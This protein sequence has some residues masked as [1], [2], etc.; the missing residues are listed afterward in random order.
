MAAE[1]IVCDIH[2]TCSMES[3]HMFETVN[4]EFGEEANKW[5]PFRPVP[6]NWSSIARIWSCAVIF[7]QV[8]Q[9]L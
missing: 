9:P 5:I 4:T 7:L 2:R 8:A 6:I 3:Q 1:L